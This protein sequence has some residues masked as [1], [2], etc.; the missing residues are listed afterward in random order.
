MGGTVL[1]VRQAAKSRSGQRTSGG[2]H[3]QGNDAWARAVCSWLGAA[4]FEF[5]LEFVREIGTPRLSRR[6]TEGSLRA[7]AF[8]GRQTCGAG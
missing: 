8:A 5:W 1:G 2:V 6:M 4:W 7:S 3:G